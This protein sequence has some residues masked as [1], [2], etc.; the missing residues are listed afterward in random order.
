MNQKFILKYLNPA[1]LQ[2]SVFKRTFESE[3]A[4][5]PKKNI[6]MSASNSILAHLWNILVLS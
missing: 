2:G 3:S 5:I 4:T 1:L 6:W